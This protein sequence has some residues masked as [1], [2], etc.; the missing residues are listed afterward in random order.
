MFFKIICISLIDNRTFHCLLVNVKEVL[1]DTDT[2]LF[3]DKNRESLY[4]IEQI[5]QTDL[6]QFFM[7][8]LSRRSVGERRLQKDIGES[9]VG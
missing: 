1:R 6:R 5:M 4:L 3:Q 8:G 2:Y 9:I 7:A